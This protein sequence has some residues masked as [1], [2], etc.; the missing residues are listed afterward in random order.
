MAFRASKEAIG[1]FSA[2][3]FLPFGNSNG[4]AMTCRNLWFFTALACALFTQPLFGF[5]KPKLTDAD[6][7]IEEA[8]AQKKLPGAVLWFQR[9]GDVYRKAYGKRALTPAEE[10]MTEDTIFDAASLTK[11][12]ATTP[13]IMLLIERGQLRLDDKVN[14]HIPGLHPDASEITI[15]HLL[16]HT[17]GLRPGIPGN[18]AWKGYELGIQ[19]ACEERPTNLPGTI[20]RY[21]DINFILLGEV[22][23]RVSGPRRE[24]GG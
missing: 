1:R 6:R 14:R 2:D 12:L 5:N 22:V 15:L 17:S 21:S 8:I 9:G 24:E 19:L 4:T 3:F 18:P 16:T 7:A 23:Q 13:A 11:V 10:A 20:F